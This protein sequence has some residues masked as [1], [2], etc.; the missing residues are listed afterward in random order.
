MESLLRIGIANAVCAAALG[1]VAAG[2]AR[3]F[4]RRP[5]IA[6][7]FWVLVLLKLLTPPVWSFELPGLASAN[8]VEMTGQ[9]FRTIE[10]GTA[11]NPSAE[12]SAPHPRLQ[13]SIQT[14]T[15][16][17][18]IW[19]AGS[20]LCA[21]VTLGR[22]RR[23]GRVLK[24]ATPAP[25]DVL[26][27]ADLVARRLGLLQAPPVAFLPGPVCPMLYCGFGRARI[28][29]PVSLWEQLSVEGRSRLLAH[30]LAH[31][32]RRDHWVRV[33]EVL[34]TIAYWWNPFLWWSRAGLHAAEEAC[35]DA[36]VAWAFPTNTSEYATA[37]VTAIEF[38]SRPPL[39][40]LCSGIGSFR[41]LKRRL[42]MIRQG[43]NVRNLGP[44]GIVLAVVIA[45]ML[46]LS[47]RL[48][49]AQSAAPKSRAAVSD[50]SYP[51]SHPATESAQEKQ[52]NENVRTRLEKTL[53]ALQFD[54]VGFSD[55]VDFLHDVSGVPVEVNWASLEASGIDR[56]APVT[57]TLRNVKFSKALSV[58]LDA[59]GG[60]RA[61]LSYAV[62]HGSIIISASDALPILLSTYDV[63]K[64]IAGAPDAG[65]KLVS[66]IVENVDPTSWQEHGGKKGLIKL[67]DGKLYVAQTPENQKAV[68][69]IIR[70]LHVEQRRG[71]KN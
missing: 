49:Q 23:F 5:A 2:A 4:P 18:S 55:V 1:F 11:L 6:H 19:L 48:A 67:E 68:A 46:P 61:K 37:L 43:T 3:V 25:A 63:H 33:I 45:T 42:I 57:A 65:Q 29:L 14:S 34:A 58:I 27:Q 71:G 44:A 26:E 47:L 17:G 66:R 15:I 10:S 69:A 32:R 7:V 16:V 28:L 31:L 53:P 36:W 9:V 70:Q 64:L 13:H 41:S 59:T 54:G 30:E 40:A 39:P 35:C 20:I 50:F 21:V 56:N 24:F 60:G 38:A 52:L 8:P 51:T 62:G 12:H 22:L